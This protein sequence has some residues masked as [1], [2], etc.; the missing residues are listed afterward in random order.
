MVDRISQDTPLKEL[1]KRHSSYA[2]YSS[3]IKLDYNI[4]PSSQNTPSKEESP[5]LK[6]KDKARVL[7][8]GCQSSINLLNN[9]TRIK[10]G[11][12]K[13]VK[14]SSKRLN[15][16]KENLIEQVD[17]KDDCKSVDSEISEDSIDMQALKDDKNSNVL[18]EFEDKIS[19]YYIPASEN[20]S[21]NYDIYVSNCIKLISYIPPINDLKSDLEEIREKV[22]Q[23]KL[24]WTT[25]R[26]LLVLDMDETLIHSDLDLKY[27]LHDTYIHLNKDQE[28]ESVIPLN[29]R[30]FLFEFLN[31]CVDQFDIVIF[32]AGCQEYADSILDYIE[33]DRKYFRYRFYRD[34][35]LNYNNI[36]LKDLGI[37][38][39]DL[40][41]VLIV[42]NCLLS[43]SHY[44]RNGILV[45]SFYT[46]TEDM[47][48]ASLVEFLKGSIL[49]AL[50]VRDVIEQTFEFCSIFDRVVNEDG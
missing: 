5:L 15:P 47:D 23:M 45:T 39:R 30:P 6:L 27:T 46:D 44:L 10:Q 49:E 34:H 29:L 14:Q 7:R 36:F 12:V 37:L 18:T 16:L 19:K 8:N 25:G 26:K 9:R 41:D 35:C 32:T 24:S 17:S 43:F 33:K 21:G 28:E 31:F 40:K 42:D 13:I 4:T 38:G 11:L 2:V 48:L 20:I 1:K 3:Q 22:N 50:D